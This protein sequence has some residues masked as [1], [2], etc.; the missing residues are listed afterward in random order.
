VGGRLKSKNLSGLI[1]T[2]FDLGI[3]AAA[4]SQNR[5]GLH[6]HICAD[7]TKLISTTGR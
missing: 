2:I 4:P 1:G 5:K 6:K 3:P 7:F